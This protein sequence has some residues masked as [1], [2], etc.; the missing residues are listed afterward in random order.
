LALDD[1]GLFRARYFGRISTPW[2]E[3]AAYR[4][5]ALLQTPEREFAVINAPPGSGKST[6]FT[7]DIP[8]WLA[9]RNRRIRAMIGSRTFPQARWYTARLRRTFERVET[10]PP[11]EDEIDAGRAVAPEASLVADFGR[12]RPV[13]RF[14]T[15]MWRAE[16]FVLAQ[17]GDIL[18]AEKEASFAA[19]G[20]DG[21][22]LGGR[23]PF[24]IWDD[25]VDKKNIRNAEV[26]AD[27][28]E[29]F[30]DQ[31]ES[32]VEPG[33]LFL[34][35]GQRLGAHDL[36]RWALDQKAGELDDWDPDDGPP[37]EDTR[38]AK[39]HHIVYRA[40]YEENCRKK[41]THRRDAPAW[42][43]GDP[44][45]GCLLDPKRLPWRD[46][47]T[48]R[49]NREEKFRVVYQQEDV[50]PK[51]VLVPMLWVT[52]G[53]DPDTG[54]EY[55]GCW[56][57][58]RGRGEIPRG[59][60]PPVFSVATAD[61]SAARYWALEW[62]LYH[63]AS[64]QRFLIDLVRTAMTADEFLDWN[65]ANGV[66]T[67]FMEEWQARSEDLG[68]PITTWVVERNAQQRFLLAYEH[69]RRWQALRRVSIIGHETQRNKLDPELGVG[70][71][72]PHW[73]FGRVRLPGRQR[74]PDGIHDPGR[75][76][77]MHLVEEVTRYP[78]SRTEDCLM[79]QWFLEANL[80]RIAPRRIDP[81]ARRL[82]RPSWL[83]A[84]A[85][86]ISPLLAR[87]N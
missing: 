59:L 62:W 1:F 33:G 12:F 43:P 29:K 47:A 67:G 7:H 20:M 5:L 27:L 74:G 41:E 54:E 77:V 58:G 42:K 83:R 79:A 25:L 23:F 34:L 80:P 73:Q 82:R 81:A 35:Q 68:V 57:T 39:Y 76:A 11:D 36:Y 9:C 22:Y 72:R 70:I 6:L 50:D 10:L 15:D 45:S 24:V 40:H 60:A 13:T 28:V 31:A 49:I 86:P 52:G 69:V 87:S 85:E 38:S 32:R 44:T 30:E 71:L 64:E 75:G 65:H 4:V 37:P 48:I 14:T 21:G 56:D 53:T 63:P 26:F 46:L 66:F 55:P 51:S 16:A 19:W 61:P 17:P 8:A 78:D 84:P 18:I 3:E 2:Q